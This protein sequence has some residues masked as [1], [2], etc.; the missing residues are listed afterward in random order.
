M[1]CSKR[2]FW[3]NVVGTVFLQL[4]WDKDDL[5]NQESVDM[6][7]CQICGTTSTSRDVVQ[8]KQRCPACQSPALARAGQQRQP[9]GKGTT[10]VVSPF[11]ALM[12]L[13]AQRW[14]QVDRLIYLSWRPRHELE[15]D[16][17]ADALKG[18]NFDTGPQQ[19]S[20]QL[21]KAIATTSDLM[22][23]PSAWNTGAFSGQVEGA[24]EQHLWIKP[25]KRFP[26]GLYQRFLGES[27]PRPLRLTDR[28]V[29]PNTNA[30]DRRS[31]HGSTTRTSPSR[32]GC[33]R[34]GRWTPSSKSRI[35]ST[36]SIR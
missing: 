13:Y 29:L 4:A 7:K 30:T 14:A 34:R 27:V 10:L 19:R 17:G 18:L 1:S 2:I 21:Y 6:W 23:T 31:G 35:R 26:D 36:K 15:D 3:V 22:L 12:P 32:A 11:E 5:L 9:V 33:T 25:C 20:L 16:Y 8:A 24:T 28:P